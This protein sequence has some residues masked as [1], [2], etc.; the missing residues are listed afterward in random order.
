MKHTIEPMGKD[1]KSTLGACDPNDHMIYIKTRQ[2]SEERLKTFCHEL[3]H[4]LENEWNFELPHSLVSRLEE[5]IVRL[6][7]DNFL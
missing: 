5:P 3:I 4:A 2:T 6:L 7:L 1:G